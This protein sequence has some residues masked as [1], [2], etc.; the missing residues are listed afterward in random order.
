MDQS[1]S[2]IDVKKDHISKFLKLLRAPKTMRRV[3]KTKSLIDYSQSQVL[4]LDEHLCSLED[5]ATKK[6]RVQIEKEQKVKER[7]SNKVKKA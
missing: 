7:K 2:P 5:I 4:T 6:E 3:K 1:Q